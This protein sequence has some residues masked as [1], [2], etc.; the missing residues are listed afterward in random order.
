MCR[1]CSDCIY[2]TFCNSQTPCEYFLPVGF[3]ELDEGQVEALIEANR[4]KFLEEFDEYISES[5]GSD[6]P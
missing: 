3:D 4:L 6:E 5:Q 2:S 1:K